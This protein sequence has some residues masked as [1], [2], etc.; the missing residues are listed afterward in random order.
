MSASDLF[1]TGTDT[2]V[3]KTILSSLLCAA[4]NRSYWKPIQTGT[5]EGSDSAAV[6]TYAGIT[7]RQVLRESYRFELPLS[8]HLAAKLAGTRIDMDAIVRPSITAPLVIE[9][10]GGVLVPINERDLMIDLMKRLKTP[11]V[12]ASRTAL[13]T[14]NHTLLSINALRGA[15][16]QLKGVVMIGDPN[17]ENRRAIEHYGDVAVIGWIPILTSINREALIGVY[18]R[19]FRREAFV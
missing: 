11:V 17:D 1:V 2:N 14:I 15:G 12:L 13:G 5:K 8:P 4:L 10:A 9:G 16:L 18:N 7:E 6:L 3:G 19:Y